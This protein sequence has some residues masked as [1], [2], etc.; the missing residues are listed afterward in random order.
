MLAGCV[1][2]NPD[3]NPPDG[4]VVTVA[5]AS[6]DD[7]QRG[8]STSTSTDASEDPPESTSDDGGGTS[9]SESGPPDAST[10][11]GAG[12]VTDDGAPAPCATGQQL[13]AGICAEIDHDKH[14][15]GEACVD[16]TERYGNNAMCV[17]GECAPH[18]SGG[19][20]DHDDD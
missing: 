9:T 17:Q 16:C 8:A 18:G 13:C 2:T 15:C 20:G 19:G 3:W 1:G 4:G 10:D 7:G 12:E 6:A 5:D 11:E 14:A